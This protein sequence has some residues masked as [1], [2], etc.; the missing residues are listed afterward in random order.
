MKLDGAFRIAKNQIL[1]KGNGADKAK[2][3]EEWQQW[4]DNKQ[5]KKG[6]IADYDTLRPRLVAAFALKRIQ[7]ALSHLIFV[8]VG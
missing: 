3:A 5:P 1:M 6:Y 4:P 8:T 7:K 2:D